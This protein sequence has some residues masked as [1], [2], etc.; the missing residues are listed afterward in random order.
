V[1]VGTARRLGDI[2]LHLE[3][4][5]KCVQQVGP[6]LGFEMEQARQGLGEEIAQLD[7]VDEAE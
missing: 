1:I 2:E 4:D 7:F 5:F 6:V 3:Q